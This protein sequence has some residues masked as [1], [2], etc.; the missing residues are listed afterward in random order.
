MTSAWPWR[1]CGTRRARRGLVC[2]AP[3]SLAASAPPTPPGGRAKLDR[4]VLLNPQLDY[5]W[6][7][8]DSRPYWS[9]DSLDEDV[10]RQL[11]KLGFIQFTPTLRHGR[12]LLNEV[13]WFDVLPALAGIQAP[14][15]VVH[16]TKDTF[17]PVE[18]SREAVTMLTAEHKLVEIEGAQ[19]GFAVHDDPRYLNRRARGGRLSSSAP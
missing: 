11:D 14:T 1:I 9:G 6:R 18:S 12:P 10:A 2:S 13:F 3:A 19:H 7:T 4:L 16:G 15:L 8:I 5:K 17:V